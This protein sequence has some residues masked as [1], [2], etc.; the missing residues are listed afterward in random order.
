MFFRKDVI[1]ILKVMKSKRNSFFKY[2][3][4]I[5]YVKIFNISLKF[6]NIFEFWNGKIYIKV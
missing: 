3:F 4:L 6:V 1:D 2:E 5:I